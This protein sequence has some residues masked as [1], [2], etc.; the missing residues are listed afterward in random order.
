MVLAVVLAVVPRMVLAVVYAAPR[1]QPSHKGLAGSDGRKR[2]GRAAG[3]R[4]RERTGDA[5]GVLVQNYVLNHSKSIVVVLF[6]QELYACKTSRPQ[7]L[8]KTAAISSMNMENQTMA[9]VEGATIICIYMYIYI[10]IMIYSI[11]VITIV[12]I[13]IIIIIIISSSSSSS[14]SSCSSSS[15]SSSSSSSSIRPDHGLG[16]RRRGV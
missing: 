11:S 15:G 1:A 13:M 16:R 10:Y 6:F 8:A 12:V 3:R 9:S 14:S 2:R 4:R 7:G 5:S